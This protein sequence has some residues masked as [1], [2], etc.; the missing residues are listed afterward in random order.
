VLPG[1]EARFLAPLDVRK[2]PGVGKVTEKN[3][4]ALGIR[5]IGDLAALDQDFLESKFG[6][7]GLAL[8]GKAFGLDA[9]SWFEFG[10]RRKEKTPSP[11]ATSIPIPKI[12]PPIGWKP[13][14]RGFP[15][16]RPPA[17]RNT[18]CT[19][20]LLGQAPLFG[21]LDD[22]ARALARPFDAAR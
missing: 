1:E 22:Y 16:G 13:L 19:P 17:S 10:L 3:L 6:K 8:A 11:S 5:K 4:H 18:A 21:L 12:P 9:G 14:W 15:S 7:W 2:I 20:E